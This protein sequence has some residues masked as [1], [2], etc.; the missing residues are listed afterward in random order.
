MMM[1][2]MLLLLMMMRRMRRMMMMMRMRMMMIIHDDGHDV[3]TNHV[4]KPI[5]L[6]TPLVLK[7]ERDKE[8][9]KRGTSENLSQKGSFVGRHRLLLGW[10]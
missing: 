2:T 3:L 10:W 1:M 4:A 9:K 6:F 7:K 8:G 5:S